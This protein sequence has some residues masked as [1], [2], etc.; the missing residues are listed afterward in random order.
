MKPTSPSRVKAGS[1]S[2][3]APA[4][5]GCPKIRFFLSK[6]GTATKLKR[7]LCAALLNPALE[8]KY[9]SRRGTPGSASST[10]KRECMGRPPAEKACA[11]VAG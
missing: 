3:N 7:P 2:L 9:A 5:L 10:E 1:P 8:P 6:L 11:G 4:M